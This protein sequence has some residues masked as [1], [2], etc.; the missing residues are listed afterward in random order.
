MIKILRKS[1]YQKLLKD[2]EDYK[3]GM[4]QFQS[5]RDTLHNYIRTIEKVCKKASEVRQNGSN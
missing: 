3:S 1:E 5:E 4:R 2:I